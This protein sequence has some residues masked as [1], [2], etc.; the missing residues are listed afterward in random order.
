VV[1]DIFLTKTAEMA[2][3]VLP[4]SSSW[5]EAEGTVTNSERRVQRVRKAIDPPHEARDDIWIIAQIAR[6]LGRDFGNPT[7]EDAWNEMRSL[8]PM[9]AGMSY[10]RIEEQCGMQ[11]PC[12]DESHPG[13]Q[14]LHARLW[15]DPPQG[16]L[17]P[18]H[19]VEHE[20]PVEQ[21]DDEFPFVLTT[22]RRLESYNTGVQSAGYDSPLHRGES[23]D[24]APE[25]AKR[26]GI[27]DGD[28]MQVTSRRGT[29][30]AP[31]RIDAA[32]KPGLVFMT[33]HFPDQVPTNFLTIDEFDPKSGTAEF[34][35]CAVRVEKA[36][37]GRAAKGLDR[38]AVSYSARRKTENKTAGTSS[39]VAA[40]EEE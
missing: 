29:L 11:W 16:K 33:L 5:C 14:F 31:A 6:R 40:A 19:A 39:V 3:V 36:V 18:F 34:K 22:G 28:L 21:P 27:A 1:Q 32:L 35:A 4:A 23:V 9:F 17:A 25:D 38:G 20:P 8:A 15:S 12:Y 37:L 10:R 30:Q 7:A 2:H 24:I 26:L 13:Q